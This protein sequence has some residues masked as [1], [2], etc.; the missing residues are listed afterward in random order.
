MQPG[1]ETWSINITS[2]IF[3]SENYTENKAVRLVPDPFIF[4]KKLKTK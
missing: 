2:E 3:F 4:F 1:I